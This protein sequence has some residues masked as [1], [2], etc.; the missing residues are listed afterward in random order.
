MLG[1]ITVLGKPGPSSRDVLLGNCIARNPHVV[2]SY[3]VVNRRPGNREAGLVYSNCSSYR[4][5]LSSVAY[6]R[7]L[8]LAT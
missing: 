4:S 2:S 1:P 7:V 5:L 8:I 3:L 6:R